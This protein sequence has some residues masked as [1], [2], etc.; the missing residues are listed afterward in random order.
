MT[1]K[2]R[3]CECLHVEGFLCNGDWSETT[4]IYTPYYLRSGHDAAGNAGVWPDNGTYRL[5]VTEACAAQIIA[6]HGR[7]A[8]YQDGRETSEAEV[9]S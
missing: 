6:L 3:Q 4:I 8:Y 1:T 9:L 7:W 2:Q 5:H